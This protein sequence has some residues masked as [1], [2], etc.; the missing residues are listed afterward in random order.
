MP[1]ESTESAVET[2]IPLNGSELNQENAPAPASQAKVKE[3][4][5]AKNLA[6]GPDGPG[7]EGKEEIKPSEKGKGSNEKE[8]TLGGY[9][10]GSGGGILSALSAMFVS[11]I[12]L[13]TSAMNALTS[14]FT[15]AGDATQ[16]SSAPANKGMQQSPGEGREDSKEK[17]GAGASKQNSQ[18]QEKQKEEEKKQKEEEKRKEEERQKEE[19]KQKEEEVKEREKAPKEGG[20][21]N[22]MPG[23]PKQDAENSA[24]SESGEEKQGDLGRIP[25]VREVL[26]SMATAGVDAAEQNNTHSSAPSTPPTPQE[27]EGVERK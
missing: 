8:P 23:G 7:K 19:E 22:I 1:K 13:L 27:S 15:G 3:E 10:K 12:N 14:L 9:E 4:A 2:T 26:S 25:G 20:L 17:D 6:E 21:N 11:L 5:E 18:K 16:G 24:L